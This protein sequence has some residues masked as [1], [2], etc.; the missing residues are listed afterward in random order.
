MKKSELRNIIREE[1]QNLNEANPSKFYETPYDKQYTTL[2]KKAIKE[3]PWDKGKPRRGT[4]HLVVTLDGN[5]KGKFY[6]L[7]ISMPG[8]DLPIW[9]WKAL[10]DYDEDKYTFNKTWRDVYKYAIENGAERYDQESWKTFNANGN[11]DK[12]LQNKNIKEFES[13]INYLKKL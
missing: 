7:L 2:I 11:V 9:T 8:L 10:N 4:R 12:N 13:A 5:V 6:R 3:I 1:I